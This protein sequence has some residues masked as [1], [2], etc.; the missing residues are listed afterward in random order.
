MREFMTKVSDYFS[1]WRDD[2]EREDGRFPRI[3]ILTSAIAVALIIALLMWWGYGVQEKRREEA[4]RKAKAL[5]EEQAARDSLDALALQEAHG[6]VSATYEEKMQEYMSKDSGEELRQEYLTNTNELSETVKELQE[7]LEQVQKE[8]SE[9]VREYRESGSSSSEKVAEKLTVLDRQ[10]QALV[11]NI[12]SLETKLTDLGSVIQTVDRE[13]IP[14]IRE[15]ITEVRSQMEQVRSDISS[16]Y[17]KIKDLRKE[18]EKL[19]NKLSGVEKSLDEALD[20]N[21]DEIDK[22]LSRVGKDMDAL[23]KEFREALQTMEKE[24]EKE[25]NEKIREEMDTLSTDS[26]SYRYDKSSSTLYL[27][28]EQKKSGR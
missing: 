18:D 10:S 15:Q 8:I 27:T 23:E 24:L 3:F 12:R 25:I 28:P 21:L 1:E 11:E 6:L 14:A 5:Q 13:K 17:D 2:P 7:K 19:W 26:L 22:R 9:V 20:K 16:T 4:A